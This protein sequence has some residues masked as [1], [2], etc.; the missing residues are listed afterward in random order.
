MWQDK[1]KEIEGKIQSKAVEYQTK[2]REIQDITQ[3]LLRLDGELRL[4]K[5]MAV[6][7]K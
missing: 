1:I 2:Q 7:E 3:E 4:A 5:E 6:D